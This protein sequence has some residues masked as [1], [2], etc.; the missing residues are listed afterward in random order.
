MLHS[1]QNILHIC[2]L[3]QTLCA[4]K[5]PVPQNVDQKPLGWRK[6]N[7]SMLLASHGLHFFFPPCIDRTTHAPP[8]PL[9][10]HYFLAS[11][12]NGENMDGYMD[13]IVDSGVDEEVLIPALPM[14]T[15]HR[16]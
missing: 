5:I 9:I 6:A 1:R 14:H 12:E 7:P 8:H 15:H 11:G 2:V 16:A 3:A 10:Y 4:N 13:A